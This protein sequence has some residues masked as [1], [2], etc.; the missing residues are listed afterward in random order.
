M[1]FRPVGGAGGAGGT[2]RRLGS[3]TVLP[4][5][6]GFDDEGT[7]AT[8]VT[9]GW[10]VTLGKPSGRATW[11][12]TPSNCQLPARM[13]TAGRSAPALD[14]RRYVPSLKNIVRSPRRTGC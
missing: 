3:H 13:Y 12:Y 2:I 11:P 5:F 8:W 14:R 1:I 9:P 7:T 6:G 4:T 10:I